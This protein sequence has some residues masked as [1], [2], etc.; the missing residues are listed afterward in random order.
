M[1][2][3]SIVRCYT[4]RT[5]DES[6]SHCAEIDGARSSQCSLQEISRR[7][8]NS[9]HSS[10]HFIRHIKRSLFFKMMTALLSKLTHAIHDATICIHTKLFAQNRTRK[11]GGKSVLLLFLEVFCV[12]CMLYIIYEFYSTFIDNQSIKRFILTTNDCP[13]DFIKTVQLP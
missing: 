2:D 5:N 3:K 12:Y 9:G 6:E 13:I 11:S 1:Y 7:P 8:P 10:T 4:A